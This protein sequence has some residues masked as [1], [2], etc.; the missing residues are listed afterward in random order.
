MTTPTK[1]LIF[2]TLTKTCHR[3]CDTQ[4]LFDTPTND[5]EYWSYSDLYN[6]F[7]AQHFDIKN[8][9]EHAYQTFD[10]TPAKSQKIPP[11]ELFKNHCV[12]YNHKY[13]IHSPHPPH[14]PIT[15][16]TTDIKLSRYACYC[17]FKN[18]SDFIFACTYFMM[19]NAD[20]ET[21]YKT[22]YRFDR[23]FQRNKLRESERNLQG[24][25][26]RLGAKYA[27]F[28]HETTKCF[29]GERESDIIRN[30]YNLGNK[31]PLADNMGAISMRYRRQA[32]DNAI[33]KFNFAHTHDLRSFA[34]ILF[35]ELKTARNQMISEYKIAPEKNIDKTPIQQVESEYKSIERDFIKQYASAN[36][37]TR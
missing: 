37:N 13:T 22:S 26:K 20:F 36:L 34:Q 31:K 25:L 2:S 24:V 18:K 30:A 21:I 3:V 8:M 27:L 14:T 12:V 23:I 9:F 5:A 11:Y 19:P 15:K 32:I 1:E 28:H 35:Q 4:T 7:G 29:Y 6:L 16:K 17:L 10:A 33:H